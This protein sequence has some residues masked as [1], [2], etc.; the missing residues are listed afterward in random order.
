MVLLQYGQPL[1][2]ERFQNR[3]RLEQKQAGGG[4]GRR[5]NRGAVPGD[6]KRSDFARTIRGEVR[7]GDEAALTL[8]RRGDDRGDVAAVKGL[9]RVLR[10]ERFE[11]RDQP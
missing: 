4:D 5:I 8:K 6:R 11:Q 1:P 10:C 2:V 3:A 9:G 7:L